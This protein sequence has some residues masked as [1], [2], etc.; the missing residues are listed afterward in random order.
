M[1]GNTTAEKMGERAAPNAKQIDRA[2]RSLAQQHS[3]LDADEAHWLRIAEDAKAWPA[4]GYVHALEYLEDVFG[5][6][7]RTA[8]ERLRV[9]RELGVLPQLEDALRVGELSYSAVRELTRV[10]TPETVEQWIEQ[11]RGRRFRDV[12]QMVSGRTKGD[13]PEDAPDPALVKHRIVLEVDGESFALWRHM[14]AMFEQLHDEKLDDKRLVVAIG[15]RV[16]RELAAGASDGSGDVANGKTAKHCAIDP[17]FLIQKISSCSGCD[18]VWQDAGGVR[19]EVDRKVL[20]RAECNAI[21]CDDEHGKRPKRTMPKRT[22]RLV[23]ERAQHRCQVPGCRSSKHLTIHHIKFFS[24][25]GTHHP[26]NLVVLCDGHHRLLHDDLLQITGRAPDRLT[27]TRTG[28]P[29]R[30]MND[31]DVA[32]AQT[33]LAE[34]SGRAPHAMT[35]HGPRAANRR[36]PSKSSA[37]RPALSEDPRALADQALRQLGFDAATAA[38][39][40]EAACANLAADAELGVFIK[41]AL[42]H[43]NHARL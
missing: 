2:L 12:E 22:A 8:M 29:M 11:A 10:A 34:G 37:G 7:P 19:V 27:F 43:C 4:L 13:R 23:L 32:S 36:S 35:K 31:N 38:S 25:G 33:L 28:T 14:Q 30:A 3:A 40:V 39:A 41:E 1:L 18:R 20:E 26:S 17:Q 15:D 21:I 9:A 5:Y 24:H 6:A 16:L 42:R